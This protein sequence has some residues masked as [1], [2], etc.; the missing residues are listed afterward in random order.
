ME[1]KKILT[2]GKIILFVLVIVIIVI[3]YFSFRIIHNSS[4]KK[5]TNFEKELITAAEN[6]YVIKDLKVDKG[7]EI[8][9]TIK[10]LS[11]TNLVYNDLKNKCNGYVIV[12]SEKNISTNKYE[13]VYRPYIKCGN[14]YMTVNYSEY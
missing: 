12:E 2:R 14:K 11:E 1:E 4:M 13:I 3:I 10:N 8:K 9:V 7:Q 5:Y 6:Y